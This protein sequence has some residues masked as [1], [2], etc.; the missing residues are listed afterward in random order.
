MFAKKQRTYQ[1]CTACKQEYVRPG[2][3]PGVLVASTSIYPVCMGCLMRG[4][5]AIKKKQALTQK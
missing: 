2:I 1:R 3:A 4:M 5:A